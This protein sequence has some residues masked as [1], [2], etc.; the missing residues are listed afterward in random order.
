MEYGFIL[1]FSLIHTFAYF[2]GFIFLFMIAGAFYIIRSGLLEKWIKS[3]KS[4]QVEQFQIQMTNKLDIINKD[5]KTQTLQVAETEKKLMTLIDNMY[6]SL[7]E[8]MQNSKEN[9]K[10]KNNEIISK[11]EQTAIS[12]KELNQQFATA[13]TRSFEQNISRLQETIVKN[14]PPATIK[15]SNDKPKHS[16]INNSLQVADEPGEDAYYLP[17]PDTKGYFWDDQKKTAKGN[18]SAFVMYPAKNNHRHARF[19]LLT[20]NQKI[21]KN[22]ILNKN[23]FLKPVCKIEGNATGNNIKVIEDGVLELVNNKWMVVVDKKVKIKIN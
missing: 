7:W 15:I 4:N 17:F 1:L 14:R 13:I 12:H 6:S 5:L 11:L 2:L 8:I 3:L 23:A 19:R 20:D 10:T 16:P 21:I 22:A 9:N 18:D